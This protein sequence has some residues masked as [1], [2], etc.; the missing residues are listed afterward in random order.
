MRTIRLKVSEL[1]EFGETPA[2]EAPDL[3]VVTALV[4]KQF[5]FLLQPLVVQ[6]EGDEVVLSFPEESEAAQAEAARLAERAAKR[7]AEGDYAK[8]I[9][10]FKR[11]LELQPS[12]HSARRD[13]AGGLTEGAAVSVRGF[14]RVCDLG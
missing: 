10:I 13:P 7:A 8:A 14:H 6:I 3:A 1:F 9:G 11:V 4:V 12:L 2:P 5:G